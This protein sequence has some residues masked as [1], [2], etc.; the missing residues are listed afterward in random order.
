MER[1]INKDEYIRQQKEKREEKEMREKIQQAWFVRLTLSL[2][3][4]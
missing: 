4:L 1:I 3:P 2:T